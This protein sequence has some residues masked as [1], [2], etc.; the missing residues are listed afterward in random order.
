MKQ[1]NLLL[2]FHPCVL[3]DIIIAE[4]GEYLLREPNGDIHQ[5]ITELYQS[6]WIYLSIPEDIAVK[7]F[8]D[9]ERII[10]KS[11]DFHI[12]ELKAFGGKFLKEH[13]E[14]KEQ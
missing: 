5:Y 10:N 12:I 7:R 4:L 1:T 13:L 8:D 14:G 9:L 3:D 11:K 6:E 2:S